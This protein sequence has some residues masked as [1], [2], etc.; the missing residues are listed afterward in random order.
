MTRKTAKRNAYKQ[1]MPLKSYL[2]GEAPSP[3]ALVRAQVHAAVRE[4]QRLARASRKEAREAAARMERVMRTA[5]LI[6]G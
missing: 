4:R 1:G 2:R 3:V 6:G 5:A